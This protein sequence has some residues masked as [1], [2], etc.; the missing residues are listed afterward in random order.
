MDILIVDDEPD[1]CFLLSHALQ[2]A[3]YRVS[4][5]TDGQAA[6]D[7][8]AAT[9]ERPRLIILDVM[10]SNMNGWEFRAWQLAD[11]ALATIPV[12]VHSAAVL[13]DANAEALQAVAV[14]HKPVDFG[15]IVALAAQYC[16]AEP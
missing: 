10:M 2:D 4:S 12:V 6:L 9:T 14:L 11:P 5:A 13:G 16:D 8:L 3:G 7:L 15:I 1:L